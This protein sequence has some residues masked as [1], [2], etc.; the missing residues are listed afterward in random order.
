MPVG[1]RKRL[2]ADAVA[3]LL[4]KPLTPE[5]VEYSFQACDPKQRGDVG[6]GVF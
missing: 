2:R 3:Q 5:A 6:V 1:E 4:F